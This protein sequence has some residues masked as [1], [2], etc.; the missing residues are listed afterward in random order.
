DNA[1][2]AR[3]LEVGKEWLGEDHPAVACLRVGVAIHH[4][5]LPSPFL[6]EVEV[7]LSEGV[8]KVI[9]ASPTLSQG[10]NLNAAVLLVPTLYRASEKI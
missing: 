7:L 8:L 3:A 4:G 2:I 9:V 5:R 6:R 10:L 1:L